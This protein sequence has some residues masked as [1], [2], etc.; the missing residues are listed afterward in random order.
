MLKVFE[1]YR[2]YKSKMRDRKVHV[3]HDINVILTGWTEW[4]RKC[5]TFDLSLQYPNVLPYLHTSLMQRRI[6]QTNI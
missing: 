1:I 5:L 6:L 2:K 4:K 3:K